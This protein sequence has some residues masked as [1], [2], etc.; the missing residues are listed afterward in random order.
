MG[1][2][3]SHSVIIPPQIS[4]FSPYTFSKA[5]ALQNLYF[6]NRSIS[7]AVAPSCYQIEGNA[8]LGT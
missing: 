7:S 1:V 3:L 4:G 6:G 2:S 5:S 8:R